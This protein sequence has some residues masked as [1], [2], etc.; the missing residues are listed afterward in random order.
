MGCFD[1]WLAES[2][3]PWARRAGADLRADLP[4]PAPG[5]AAIPELPAVPVEHQ[6]AYG[7]VLELL[8]RA[9]RGGAWPET[10]EGRSKV[11]YSALSVTPTPAALQ[12]T[13]DPNPNGR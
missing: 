2:V 9:D 10:S 5:P 12:R 3:R 13:A 4:H 7:R 8:R 11:G 1:A 6:G